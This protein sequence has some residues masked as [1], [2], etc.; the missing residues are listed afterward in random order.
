MP[1]QF[2]VEP[3][4]ERILTSAVTQSDVPHGEER[5]ENRAAVRLFSALWVR[6]WGP[7]ASPDFLSS[8]KKSIKT[9]RPVYAVGWTIIDGWY[10]WSVSHKTQQWSNIMNMVWSSGK[11]QRSNGTVRG[12]SRPDRVTPGRPDSCLIDFDRWRRTLPDSSDFW[13]LVIVPARRTRSFFGRSCRWGSTRS[14]VSQIN[15]FFSISNFARRILYYVFFWPIV[16]CSRT[17]FEH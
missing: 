11:P 5:R 7:H 9:K 12:K 15:F 2:I 10:R 1:A 6:E 16:F 4:L 17:L 13:F 14:S 3:Q 8:R